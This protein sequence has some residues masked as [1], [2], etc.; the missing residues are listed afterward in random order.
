VKKLT[1]LSGLPASG[2]STLA[3]KKLDEDRNLGRIN[4][5]DL[6][7]MIFNG[8]WSNYNEKIIVET[9][10]AIAKVLL[11]HDRNVVVDDTNLSV[12]H[13]NLWIEFSKSQEAKF[14]KVVVDT[15][16]QT[17]LNRDRTRKESVGANV[18]LKMAA[19][20]G[21]LKWPDKPIVLCDIDG[22]LA[23]GS[24]RENWVK[25]EHKDWDTYFSLLHFDEPVI[26]IFK[27]LSELTKDHTIVVVSG[28]GAEYE[29]QT[30]L[31]FN[32]VWQPNPLFPERD[33]PRFD[34]FT[35]FFRDKGDRRPDDQV[36]K[37]FLSL[38]PKRPELIIDDRPAVVR[39]WREQ[40]L[41]V[42]P[43]RGACEEF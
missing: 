43:V 3:R 22:T 16:V 36:K 32:K 2:K 23:D 9:E 41:K 4:R 6:R 17:C 1:M 7:K 27:W 31:W 12:K 13:E 11:E 30:R 38:L 40:G 25:G 10:K 42:I 34:I 20:N 26:P 33:V 21:L 24:H 18:I 5:D 15:D 8:R 29:V 14:E 28:R 39:M 37:E 35:F 19:R